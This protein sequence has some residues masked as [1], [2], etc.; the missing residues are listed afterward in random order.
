MPP[1]VPPIRMANGR[2][3]ASATMSSCSER[4]PDSRGATRGHDRGVG[5]DIGHEGRGHHQAGHQAGHEQ[6]RHRGFGKRAVDDHAE[7]RRQQNAERA[8][9]RQRTRRQAPVVI[10]ADE[11]RQRH[12]ADRSRGRDARSAHRGEDR[13]AGDVGLQQSAGK[14]CH[15][16][17]KAAIDA[18]AQAADAKNFRHQHEQ[19]HAGQHETVHA[20]PAHQPQ[21]VEARQAA[22]QQQIKHRRNRDRKRHRHSARRAGQ[23]KRRR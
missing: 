15:E 12:A 2:T 5:A 17:G 8:A 7:T 23:E 1:S 18:A 4:G 9:G 19:R 16:L 10:A 20:A 21:A 22:L 11:L 13:A 6:F 14:F 3:S